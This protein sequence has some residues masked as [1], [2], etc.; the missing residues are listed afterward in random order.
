M[1]S[2]PGEAAGKAAVEETER[3]LALQRAADACREE[4]AELCA[5]V[6]IKV[7]ARDIAGWLTR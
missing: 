4:V 1:A 3:C 2:P 7:A 6:G 5:I